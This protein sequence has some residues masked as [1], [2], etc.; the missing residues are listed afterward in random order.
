M[1]HA[2]P[3]AGVP[4]LVPALHH[5]LEKLRE[6]HPPDHPVIR[7]AFRDVRVAV[8]ERHL[9]QLAADEELTD[10]DRAVLVAAVGSTAP[11]APDAP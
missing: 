7:E 4:D 2:S 5:R 11:G 8:A 6:R 10:A 9:R 3:M 1:A